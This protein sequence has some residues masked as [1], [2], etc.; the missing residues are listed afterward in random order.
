MEHSFSQVALVPHSRAVGTV[1]KW[2]LLSWCLHNRA[3]LVLI[4]EVLLSVISRACIMKVS[5]LGPVV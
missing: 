2:S 5:F 4:S 3:V 1:N